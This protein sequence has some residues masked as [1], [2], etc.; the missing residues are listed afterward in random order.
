M[1]GPGLETD[2]VANAYRLK[3]G[4]S[5]QADTGRIRLRHSAVGSEKALEP[6]KRAKIGKKRFSNPPFLPVGSNVKC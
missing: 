2:P 1:P 3:A 4:R 6:K 5:Q